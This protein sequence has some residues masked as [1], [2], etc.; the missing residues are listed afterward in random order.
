M[1]AAFNPK[2]RRSPVTS[3]TPSRRCSLSATAVTAQ[4]RSS[5]IARPSEYSERSVIQNVPMLE[6]S[7]YQNQMISPVPPHAAT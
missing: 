1:S 4:L 2:P 5:A 7:Q 3:R 6:N